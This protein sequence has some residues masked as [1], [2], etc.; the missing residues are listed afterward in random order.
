MGDQEHLNL[1]R[2]S[3]RYFVE[4]SAPVLLAIPVCSFQRDRS[5]YT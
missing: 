4:E 5:N 3:P 2:P 1:D